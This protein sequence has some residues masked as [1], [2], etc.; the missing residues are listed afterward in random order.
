LG[1]SGPEAALDAIVMR[2]LEKKPERRY[3]SMGEVVQALASVAPPMLTDA[4]PS[5]AERS[6]G[7][8]MT[9]E[10]GPVSARP[11]KRR[12]VWVLA[13]AAGAGLGLAYT[14][15]SSVRSEPEMSAAAPSAAAI[16]APANAAPGAPSAPREARPSAAPS[17]ESTPAETSSEKRRPL[18]GPKASPTTTAA[19]AP[20][21][22][23]KGGKG[24]AFSGTDIVN[25]WGE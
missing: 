13:L 6:D 5:S 22:P 25:P 7:E 1:A 16:A 9:F 2:C 12:L 4:P 15:Y 11:G 23:A 3:A 21:P 10:A 8:P 17:T 19:S 14:A 20:K 18:P 24:A